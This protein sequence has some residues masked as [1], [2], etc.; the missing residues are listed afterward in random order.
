MG[1]AERVAMSKW[2]ILVFLLSPLVFSASALAGDDRPVSE[3]AASIPSDKSEEPSELILRLGN[4]SNPV[5]GLFGPLTYGARASRKFENGYAVEA[6]YVR[7]HEPAAAAFASFVDE[8]QLTLRLPEYRSFTVSATAWQNRMIDM[9]TNLVGLELSRKGPV[10]FLAGAYVGTATR[11]DLKGNFRGSQVAISGP[12]GPIGL[13]AAALVGKI[14]DGSYRKLGLEASMD[15]G[16]DDKI[17]FALSFAAEDRYFAFGNGGPLSD[18]RD[19]VIFVLAL[20][21][22][23]EKLVSNRVS[24]TH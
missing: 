3:G 6:G 12:L 24:E 20:E 16:G 17:P 19:E 22:H 15:F 7:L 4:E 11:E 13:T 8:A 9:Y 1:M 18:P 21:L 23:F 10:S 2:V 5:D 14:D